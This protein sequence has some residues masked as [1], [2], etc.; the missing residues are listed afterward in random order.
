MDVTRRIGHPIRERERSLVGVT[1]FYSTRDPEQGSF[2]YTR[3]IVSRSMEDDVDCSTDHTTS[4]Y[5]T[6]EAYGS[7]TPGSVVPVE[8]GVTGTSTS[9]CKQ[10]RT[11][12]GVY[13]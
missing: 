4:I 1:W 10:R 6:A 9:H 8:G 7:E 11:L 5:V 3:H 2:W 12:E 13:V